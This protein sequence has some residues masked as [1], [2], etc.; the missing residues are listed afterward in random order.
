MKKVILAVL[1]IAFTLF[2]VLPKLSWAQGLVSVS[3]QKASAAHP[4]IRVE[5]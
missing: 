5:K 1:A 2:L 4:A 3:T